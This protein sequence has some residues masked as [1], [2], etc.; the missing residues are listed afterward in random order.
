MK[1]TSC[2]LL[3]ALSLRAKT[4]SFSSHRNHI[5]DTVYVRLGNGDATFRNAGSATLAPISSA[6]RSF[7][8]RLAIGDFN[9]DGK[10]D[11]AV[12]GGPRTGLSVLLG[13]GD[14]TFQPAQVTTLAPVTTLADATSG[15]IVFA[16]D[17]DGDGKLDLVVTAK[18]GFVSVLLG[19]G[20]GTFQAPANIDLNSDSKDDPDDS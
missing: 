5:G 8:S 12:A 2:A 10:L 1:K 16:G 13:Q 20:D 15:F 6:P 14:G 19:K 4:V 7:Q 17:F 18:K 9:G 3:L 11:L